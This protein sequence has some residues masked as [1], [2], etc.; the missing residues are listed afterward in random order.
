MER[1]SVDYVVSASNCWGGCDVAVGEALRVRADG[2]V[3]IGHAPFMR[4]DSV[5]VFYLEGRYLDPEP[6][7]NVLGPTIEQLSGHSRVGLGMS[8]QWLNFLDL[9][10][11]KLND[12]GIEAVTG[13]AEGRLA[14]RGQV[15]GCDYTPLMKLKGAVDVYL[16]IGSLFHSLG[17]AMTS[18]KPTLSADP[19]TCKV[20]WANEL[21]DR[22]YRQR[23]A[24][25]ERFKSARKIGVILSTKPGQYLPGLAKR[26]TSL[27]KDR[28]YEADELVTDEVN[29]YLLM[30]QRY[31]AYV[32]SAC[33]RLSVED[34]SKFTK[35][36]LL[37]SEV[38]VALNI[39][40]WSEFLE[41]GLLFRMYV[42]GGV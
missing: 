34:Q 8:V 35:P 37:P 20:L 16:C 31:D 38:L 22:M 28:G 12:H 7:L 33:P 18:S 14:H 26:I 30:D 3:H 27:L 36:L 19:H 11:S 42:P 17:L 40:S 2:I 21:A 4:I 39:I 23:Y 25:I 5:K 15:I 10:I 41:R 32:N 9:V 1:S 13:E 6:L 24:N 29:E